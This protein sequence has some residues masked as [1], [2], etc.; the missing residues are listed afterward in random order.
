M[1]I[2]LPLLINALSKY[3]PLVHKTIT[4]LK[5]CMKVVEMQEL[6]GYIN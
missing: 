3:V 6:K 1:Y 4:P 5:V 2:I